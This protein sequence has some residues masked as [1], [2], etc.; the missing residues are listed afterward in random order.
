MIQRE[1]DREIDQ[2]K[3]MIRILARRGYIYKSELKRLL[4]GCRAN[5]L[6]LSGIE[7]LMYSV[8]DNSIS[9]I[10]DTSV[11][12]PFH[13][14]ILI[15]EQI[16]K[17]GYTDLFQYLSVS[18]DSTLVEIASAYQRKQAQDSEDD[19]YGQLGLLI[20]MDKFLESYRDLLPAKEILHELS[21][22][23]QFGLTSVTEEEL[24]NFINGLVINFSMDRHL[25]KSV[26]EKCLQEYDIVLSP[27]KERMVTESKD[28]E[29][30]EF[31][32]PIKNN[33]EQMNKNN[34]GLTNGRY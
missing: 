33:T 8:I 22:R 31:L 7:A 19:L 29:L 30:D 2:V 1:M 4:C 11:S 24:E 3:Q 20:K 13:D 9:Y 25:A 18:E 34:R 27:K 16:E 21:L 26:V 15:Q 6:F 14:C 17:A 5:A 28:V 23:R 32:I 10:D 12:D